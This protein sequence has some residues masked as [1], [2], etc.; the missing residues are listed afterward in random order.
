MEQEGRSESL[1]SEARQVFDTH[2]NNVLYL[3]CAI[4]RD[5]DEINDPIHELE[6]ITAVRRDTVTNLVDNLPDTTESIASALAHIS[7]SID[8][9]KKYVDEIAA[10]LQANTRVHPFL[11]E[12]ML[13]MM[14][15]FAEAYLEDAL[16]LLTTA[17]PALMATKE[18]VVSGNDVLSIDAELPAE[19]R[20]QRLMEIMRQRWATQF[21]RGPQGQ[22]LSRLEKFG[23]PEYRPGLAEEMAT[24]WKRRHAIVHARPAAQSGHVSGSIDAAKARYSQSMNGFIGATRVISSFVTATD[25]FVV[26]Y[27][28][29]RRSSGQGKAGCAKSQPTAPSPVAG[30]PP[31]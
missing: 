10:L 19:R 17:G 7:I 15:T 24:V 11:F 13:A 23:V 2:S 6:K 5:I 20:W 18:V 21:L 8:S 27:L 25:A 30:N 9:S 16:L 26:D 14:V 12:W 22:W 4:L 31:A 29:G 1:G 28:D 3:F